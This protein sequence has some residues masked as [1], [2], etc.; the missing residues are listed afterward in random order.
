MPDETAWR[1]R[2]TKARADKDHEFATSEDAPI[3]AVD[4]LE[5]VTAGH[6]ALDGQTLRFDAEASP[7][8]RLHWRTADHR[9][10]WQAPVKATAFH[11][12]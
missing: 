4:T 8:A 2:L 3:A 10:S 5:S 9:G 6:L 11:G 1:A 7:A 12:G